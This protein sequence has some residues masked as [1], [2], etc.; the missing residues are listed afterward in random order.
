MFSIPFA[1]HRKSA[2]QPMGWGSVVPPWGASLGPLPSLVI[3]ST[4]RW[5]R[6]A[7]D[8]GTAKFERCSQHPRTEAHSASNSAAAATATHV[9]VVCIPSARM[10]LSPSTHVLVD[11]AGVGIDVGVED[12][13][14]ALEGVGKPVCRPGAVVAASGEPEGQACRNAQRGI[15]KAQRLSAAS[16]ISFIG[17]PST[18]LN[19]RAGFVVYKAPLRSF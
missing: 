15:R 13:A 17:L 14:E 16:A 3:T 8:K 9:L 10:S 1:A 11:V 5:H 18:W 19:A 12:D 6:E 2:S 4:C 7:T